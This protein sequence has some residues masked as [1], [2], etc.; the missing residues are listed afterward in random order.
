MVFLKFLLPFFFLSLHTPIFIPSL[1]FYIGIRM[2]FLFNFLKNINSKEISLPIPEENQERIKCKKT[3]RI[4]IQQQ[5]NN[6]RRKNYKI[7]D[8]FPEKRNKKKRKEIILMNGT[9][10]KMNKTQEEKK[11]KLR[12]KD[13]EFFS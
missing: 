5:H 13:V 9:P 11:K 7:Q 2:S 10:T 4:S 8:E 1:L 3:D 12:T 6:R